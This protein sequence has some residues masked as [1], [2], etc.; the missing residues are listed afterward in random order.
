MRSGRLFAFLRLE[1]LRLRTEAASLKQ[2]N[3]PAHRRCRDIAPNMKY[4]SRYGDPLLPG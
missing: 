2:R 3:E 1:T 4:N